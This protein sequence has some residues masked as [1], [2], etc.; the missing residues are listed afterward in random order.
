MPSPL[1]PRP[2]LAACQKSQDEAPGVTILVADVIFGPLCPEI[3][4]WPV[5][6]QV[7]WK[8]L[9]RSVESQ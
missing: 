4:A 6:R 9:E 8:V 7:D 3:G 5:Q 2:D 1:E